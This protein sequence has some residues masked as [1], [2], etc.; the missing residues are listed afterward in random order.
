MITISIDTLNLIINVIIR[1]LTAIILLSLVIPLQVKEAQVIDGLKKLRFEM[2]GSGIIIFLVNTI[3]LGVVVYHYLF[4][5][6]DLALISNIIFY[7]NSIGF[8]IF[9]LIKFNVYHTQYTTENKKI[10][11]KQKKIKNTLTQ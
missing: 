10:H 4:P 7:F 3:G 8:L 6:A 11:E 9:A 2:L 5:T 1:I